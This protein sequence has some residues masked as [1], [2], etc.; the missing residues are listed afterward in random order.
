MKRIRRIAIAGAGLSG[1]AVAVALRDRGFDGSIAIVDAKRQ[2]DNDRTWCW[3]RTDDVP[4][5]EIATRSWTRFRVSHAG[6]DGI[7]ESTRHPYVHVSA[8]DYY[9]ACQARLAGTD[10]AISLDEPIVRI[11]RDGRSARIQTTRREFTADL[12]VDA[13][14]RREHAPLHQHFLGIH[15]VADEAVFD[16]ETVTLMDF[17][18]ARSGIRFM[19]VLPFSPYEALV[20]DTAVDRA[21][22]D[23]AERRRGVERYLHERYGLRTWREKRTEVGVIPLD[24]RRMPTFASPSVVRAGIGAGATRASSGYTYVRTHRHARAIADFVMTGRPPASAGSGASALL[25]AAALHA[26]QR[27]AIDIPRILTQVFAHAPGDALARFL[28]DAAKPRDAF[29][30]IAAIA[31]ALPGSVRRFQRGRVR[32]AEDPP[33]SIMTPS[34]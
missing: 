2:F 3:W 18:P 15:V 19:Y 33:L 25:D 20:E 8:I 11:A 12:V 31:Q 34:R 26:V 24:A 23:P 9:T 13:R 32:E 14:G 10:T 29:E 4:F 6:R 28:N 7:A 22:P 1:F 17:V 16:P 30:V 5:A 21:D 27:E